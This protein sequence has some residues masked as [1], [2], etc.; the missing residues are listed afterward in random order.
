MRPDNDGAH[1]ST[2]TSHDARPTNV[3][4]LRSGAPHERSHAPGRVGHEQSARY[5]EFP[6][7]RV[8]THLYE[9]FQLT[10]ARHAQQLFD[11][12]GDVELVA[13]HQGLTLRAETED[14]I[15]ASVAVLR[16]FYGPQIEIG[17]PTIRYHDGVTLEQPW[18]GLRVQCPARY[19]EPVKTDLIVRDAT[20]V[21]FQIQLGEC[22]IRARAPLAYLIGY[23]AGLSELTS[24]SAQCAMWLSHYAPVDRIPPDGDAA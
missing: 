5:P 11:A 1:A 21:S 15:D 18:M 16:K 2:D 23:S 12:R 22:D 4:S 20:L 10:F 7:E 19:L 24:G 14:A 8:C 13:S 9:P 3:V 17:P 6:I